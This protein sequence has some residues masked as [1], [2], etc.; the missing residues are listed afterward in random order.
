MNRMFPSPLGWTAPAEGHKFKF[1]LL[2]NEFNNSFLSLSHKKMK[3]SGTTLTLNVNK[4]R[5]KI[6]KYKSKN[7]KN[8]IFFIYN[9]LEFFN[10]LEFYKK[11]SP[12][13]PLHPNPIKKVFI[14]TLTTNYKITYTIKKKIN[15]PQTIILIF[16]LKSE[17][18]KCYQFL[19]KKRFLLFQ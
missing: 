5:N 19:I 10:K 13:L 2:V 18:I 9:K 16:E 1:N 3:S 7:I 8:L 6:I 12:V 11:N 17:K 4:K 15:V 14:L